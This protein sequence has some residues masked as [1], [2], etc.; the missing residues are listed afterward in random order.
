LAST[1]SKYSVEL[2]L[3][4]TFLGCWNYNTQ[5]HLWRYVFTGEYVRDRVVMDI[6]CGVGYGTR[7]LGERG[8]KKVFGVDL[9]ANSLRFARSSY[10]FH[11]IKYIHANGLQLPF[12]NES[13]DIAVSFETIEHLP[14]EHQE[15]FVAEIHRVVRPQGMFICSSLNHEFSPGHVDHTR[16]FLPNELFSMIGSH[17]GQIQE[18]GQYISA[19]D[20]AF[21]RLQTRRIGFQLRRKRNILLRRARNWF[22]AEPA[23]MV[24]RNLIKRVLRR[25]NSPRPPREPV[26]LTDTLIGNLDPQYAPV[27]LSEGNAGALFDPIAVCFK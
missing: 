2:E 14:I 16:E 8:A 20:L 22:R 7:F 12:E 25:N 17:F 3:F 26:Y 10:N 5:M 27:L 11:N 4:D 19:E 1:L 6:A 15:A 21:Q 24:L 18:Y 23:R 9:D 13:I